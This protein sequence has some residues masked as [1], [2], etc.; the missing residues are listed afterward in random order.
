MHIFIS[1]LKFVLYKNIIFWRKNVVLKISHQIFWPNLTT[2]L[3]IYMY[4]YC[5][6][7]LTPIVLL[8]QYQSRYNLL[9][10]SVSINPDTTLCFLKLVSI[11]IQLSLCSSKYQSR[12]NNFCIRQ[13]LS[14]EIQLAQTLYAPII[15]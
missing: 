6:K 2:F 15:L 9:Y 3:S 10:S 7:R 5:N 8:S 4:L 11:L 12:Y 13:Y 14:I 1:R